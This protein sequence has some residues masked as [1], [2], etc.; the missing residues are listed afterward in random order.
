MIP[1]NA[2]GTGGSE[3]TGMAKEFTAHTS[4]NAGTSE[5]TRGLRCSPPVKADGAHSSRV[6]R[7]PLMATATRPAVVLAGRPAA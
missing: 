5:R 6:E 1:L 3:L 4:P 2:L 7:I